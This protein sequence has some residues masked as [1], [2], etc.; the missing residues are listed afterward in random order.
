MDIRLKTVEYT[1]YPTIG[2]YYKEDGQDK[3]TVLS[4]GIDTYDRLVAI[5]EL[6]EQTCTQ[7]LGITEEEITNF[8]LIHLDADEPGE[9]FNSPYKR[10]HI[11]AETIERLICNHLNI[12]WKEYNNHLDKVFNG[13]NRS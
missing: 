13:E 12:D 3:I 10:E 9:L 6:V 5:H 4:T 2:D 1:R 7:Y 8:D 11:L